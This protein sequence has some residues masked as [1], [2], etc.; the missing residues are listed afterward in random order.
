MFDDLRL[1]TFDL[2]DT[3]WPCA[4]V[5]S[6]AEH[7]VHDWLV[8]N[9]PSLAADHDVASLRAHR[10]QFARENSSISH[11]LTMT[12]LGSLRDLMAKY[13]YSGELAEEGVEIFRHYRNQV[14]PYEDVIPVLTRLKARY[15]LI[16]LTNGNVQMEKTALDGIF[17][18][19]LNAVDA[20]AARPDPAL[21]HLAL[22][23]AGV[24]PSQ[25]LHIGD[26]PVNDVD[27]AQRV[28]FSAGWMQ[29]TEMAWPG[30]L[31]PAEIEL[32]D[33]Q[34]LLSLLMK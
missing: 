4:P 17:D 13:G 15:A 21:F 28:G 7:K 26:H 33:L 16:S 14:Q 6:R 18:Y 10:L 5:I 3:L 23:K 30:E 1:I 32:K 8:D 20:G 31:Q 19:S 24:S 25:A 34:P 2:D 11:D 12:R 22:E 9:A 27:A 29:R